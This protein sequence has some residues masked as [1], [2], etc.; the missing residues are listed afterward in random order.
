MIIVS[1]MKVF[2]NEV[3]SVLAEHPAVLECGVVG[4]PDEHSGQAVKAFVVFRKGQTATEDELREHCRRGLTGYKVPRLFEYR[5]S[6]PKTN[7]GKI[8][9]RELEHPQASRAA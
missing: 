3:E 6:L 9:R 4:V 2:P 7:I 5:D 1:G 8:L